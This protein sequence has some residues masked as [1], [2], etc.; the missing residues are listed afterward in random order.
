MNMLGDRAKDRRHNSSVCAP[1]VLVVLY[2]A[3][4]HVLP[5]LPILAEL[6]RVGCRVTATTGATFADR[7]RATGA[8]AVTYTTPLTDTAPPDRLTADELAWRMVSY[9]EEVLAVSPVI[10]SCARPDVM[11]YDT[12][13]WA[14]ARVIA[15]EW[16][17]PMIQAVPTF[18]SNK[19]FSVAER[20]GRIAPPIDPAHPALAQ[21]VQLLTDYSNEH[22][23]PKEHGDEV[24]SGHGHPT[25]VTI[26]RAF[27]FFGETF[28]DDHVFVGPCLE[29]PGAGSTYGHAAAGWRPTADS[30]PLALISLGTTVNDKPDLFRHCAEA[31]ADTEWQL[32]MTVG[33]RFDP[34]ALGP[35]PANVEVHRWLPHEQV[36]RH[37]SV[38]VCQGGMGSVQQSMYHAVPMVV[39]PHHHEQ[40]ANAERIAELGLGHVLARESLTADLVRDTVLRVANDPR[41]AAQAHVMRE[42]I[43]ASGGAPL[44]AQTIVAHA[45]RETSLLVPAAG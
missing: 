11:V 42:D 38:F 39:I 21:F 14:P 1:H 34:A 15:V 4:G 24:M 17:C 29:T 35:L 37:A 18:A 22:H 23:V 19:H 6:V 45:S 12:S 3:F 43:R 26:T 31:F 40:Q 5:M 8:E 7:V 13:L 20:L 9:L 2:P 44:A 30:G 25:I 16:G 41:I 28:G 27:Q 32:V 36:L 10:E 33:G